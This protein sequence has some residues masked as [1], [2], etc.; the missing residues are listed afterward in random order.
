MRA[1][2]IGQPRPS[3]P[4]ARSSA[5]VRRRLVVTILSV[6]SLTLV[7]VYFREADGGLLHNVQSGGASVLRP[8][9]VGAERV[10]RPFRDAAGW[11]GGLID[12]KDE[13]KKLRRERDQARQQAIL[14]QSAVRENAQLKAILGYLDSP[15][16]PK[17]YRAV[18]TRVIGRPGRQFADQIVVGAG[19]NSGLS[20][21]DVVVNAEGLV[22]EVTKVASKSRSSRCSP[23]RRAPSRP[24]TSRRTRPASPSAA[25][26]ARSRS[27]G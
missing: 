4:A 17:D 24:W 6:L 20:R 22:G 2:A 13:N 8:F 23:T 1:A 12:A 14:N 26:R 25:A 21:H 10:A 19:K 5:V 27:T 3:T 7:T 9:E 11:F 18:T 15:R 16:F